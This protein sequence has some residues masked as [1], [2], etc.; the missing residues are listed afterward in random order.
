M[1]INYSLVGLGGIA[2]I[3]LMALKTLPLLNLQLDSDIKLNTLLTT[4]KGKNNRNAHLIGFENVVETLE[5]LIKNSSINVVDI[6]TP[7][8]LHKEQIMKSLKAGKHVYCEKPLA[9][10]K[11]EG[12]EILDV[13]GSRS[14]HNQIGFVLRFLPAVA[15]A[16][17]LI[18]NNALGKIYTIR[19]EI[20]HSS[21]LNPQKKLTWRLMREKSGGGAL[22]D[23]GSHMIDLIHFLLGEL[24]T[25]QAF[26]DTIV[27]QRV[28]GNEEIRE[29]DVDDWVLLIIKLKNGI[30]GTI[31]ASRIAVG[32]EG[33]RI[34]IY[35]E[36]GS[37]YLSPTDDPY[38][39]K[40]FDEESKEVSINDE[41]II[42][43][44]YVHKLLGLYP[45]P[46]LSQ[47]WM[48][49]SHTA[50]LAWFLRNIESNNKDLITPDFKE[51]YKTQVVIDCGYK[52]A[53]KDGMP[54]LVNY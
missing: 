53:N 35:G 20:Y 50:S 37:I 12:K 18:K 30:K 19:A 3:H 41:S 27:T 8:Y 54:F 43:D 2:R 34:E 48:V 38:F 32:N 1:K 52:S 9:L 14:S 40:F 22:A 33:I 10:N 6:C 23:L 46:K 4:H 42:G 29:V 51:A 45:S 26:T 36:K 16:R 31:E 11:T 5:E 44:K 17:A 15:R 28:T 39:P 47:G 24:E 7:N 21:Y 25:V 49:D 13:L